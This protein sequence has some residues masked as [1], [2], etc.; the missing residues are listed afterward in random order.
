MFGGVKPGVGLILTAPAAV[1]GAHASAS[2]AGSA[3]G[4]AASTARPARTPPA[5]IAGWKPVSAPFIA[6]TVPMDIPLTGG[7]SRLYL[8]WITKLAPVATGFAASI[9]EAQLQTAARLQ[10]Q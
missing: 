3:A 8:V 5:T 1:A 9:A 10:A 7:P 2:T 4:R 6:R